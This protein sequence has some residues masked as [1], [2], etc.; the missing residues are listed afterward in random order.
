MGLEG[1]AAG[2]SHTDVAKILDG[3]VRDLAELSGGNFV[4]GSSGYNEHPTENERIHCLI[5]LVDALTVTGMDKEVARKI[6]DIRSEANKRN[7]NPI[8]ILTKIDS[9]CEDTEA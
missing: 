5:I 8:F 9:L 2:L 6:K 7:L 4:P 3:Y 1:G